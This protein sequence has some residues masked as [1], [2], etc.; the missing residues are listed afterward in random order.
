MEVVGAV[1]Q[2]LGVLTHAPSGRPRF[3]SQALRRSIVVGYMG[4]RYTSPWRNSSSFAAL[5]GSLAVGLTL[6]RGLLRVKGL[7]QDAMDPLPLAA[8]QVLLAL[9]TFGFLMFV[10]PLMRRARLIL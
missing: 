2:I 5:A 7:S 4:L 3:V 6:I 1:Q 9:A 10:N 8:S